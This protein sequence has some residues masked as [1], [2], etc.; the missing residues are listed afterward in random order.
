MAA[1]WD[2]GTSEAPWGAGSVVAL[3]YDEALS[4]GQFVDTV[5]GAYRL[6][7]QTDGNLVLLRLPDTVLWDAGILGGAVTVMQGDGNL[8]IYDG[9]GTALWA[10]DTDGN[11]GGFLVLQGDGNLVIYN[12]G[13]IENLG[14]LTPQP[15][16]AG[17]LTETLIWMTSVTASPQMVEQRMGLRLSPRQQWEI[18]YT[19]WGPP[20]TYLDLLTMAGGGSPLYLPL[21]E[22]P[23]H[24]TMTT[25]L[26]GKTLY[27]DDIANTALA[28]TRL[29]VLLGDD[30]W[31]SEVVEVFARGGN[32]LTLVAGLK[33]YWSAGARIYACKKVRVETHLSGSRHNDRAYVA[34]ARYESLE[35]NLTTASVTLDEYEDYY[36]ITEDPNDANSLTHTYD[37]KWFEL[38]R[39]TGVQ[40]ISDVG[41]FTHQSHAFWARGRAAHR[42]LRAL[43]YA[44]DGRRVP[45]WVPSNFADFDL[46]EPVNASDTSI[47]IR[48]CGYTDAGG[49]FYRRDHIMVYLR[50]GTRLY[51]AIIAAAVHEDGKHEVIGLDPPL[52]RYIRLD[53]V[54]RIS[55]LM[56]SRLDQDSVEFVHPT[57]TLGV[58]TVNTVFRTDPGIGPHYAP[59]WHGF[60]L[61]MLPGMAP[62]SSIYPV[63]LSG[64]GRTAVGY[65]EMD[66]D[67]GSGGTLRWQAVVWDLG[68]PNQ[69][70]TSNITPYPQQWSP[71][72]LTEHQFSGIGK[73]NSV[74][75]G[76]AVDTNV[77]YEG[78]VLGGFWR[79]GVPYL[80]SPLDPVFNQLTTGGMSSDATRIVGRSRIGPAYRA[81]YWDINNPTVPVMLP[82]IPEANGG[83]SPSTP[84][85]NDS[86]FGISDDKTVIWGNCTIPNPPFVRPVKWINGGTPVILPDNNTS[87]GAH[88]QYGSNDGTIGVGFEGNFTALYWPG[89]TTVVSLPHLNENHLSIATDVTRMPGRVRIVGS[90]D[91]LPVIWDNENITTILPRPE[92]G[93]WRTDGGYTSAQAIRVSDNGKVILGQG[94]DP[95]DPINVNRAIVWK[96]Y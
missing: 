55:F 33:Q 84:Y 87:Q 42:R 38:D 31:T 50:D 40:R 3:A 25:A 77:V 76:F 70:P 16:W 36:V 75:A 80:L 13:G 52:G 32:Q 5:G 54:R 37:R 72:D 63:D 94:D 83:W 82:T 62:G 53:Q 66:S 59:R 88:L 91:N 49:P 9:G 43:F 89:N 65:V 48:R 11:P 86:G 35:P 93:E 41:G 15:D 74:F 28:D 8:V 18:G 60:Y 57:D 92:I 34:K 4:P 10:S 68:P 20:R 22:D 19:S 71:S 26:G 81:C 47:T 73:N 61:Q 17:G 67:P 29:A 12:D 6:S 1:I 64:D 27:V 39:N 21:W 2:T 45:I 90:S 46:A 44:L 30:L 78:Q 51:R 14:V 79:N 96:F 56:L 95:I 24:L 23:C 85:Q 58:T 69:P 7:F